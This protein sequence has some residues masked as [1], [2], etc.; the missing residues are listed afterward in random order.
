VERDQ[1]LVEHF[2]KIDHGDWVFHEYLQASS[3]VLS[4]TA[5]D[6]QLLLKDIYEDVIFT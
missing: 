4:L 1:Y 2:R 5:V 6:A 3:D